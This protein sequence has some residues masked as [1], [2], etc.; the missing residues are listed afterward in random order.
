MAGLAIRAGDQAE[1]SGRVKVQV[2]KALAE[3]EVHRNVAM[4]Q[5]DAELEKAVAD[6]WAQVA[7]ALARQNQ[8]LPEEEQAPKK[9]QGTR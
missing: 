1:I 6:A 9:E 3:A 5:A 2:D 4:A 8:T 7:A